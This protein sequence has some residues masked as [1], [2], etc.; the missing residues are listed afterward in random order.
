AR[1]MPRSAGVRSILPLDLL[2]NG[3]DYEQ[4]HGGNLRHMIAQEGAPSLTWRSTPLD[5][6]LGHCRL[7]DLKSGLEQFAVD[8]PRSPKWVLDA[9]SP[10]QSAQLRVD[11]RPPSNQARLPTPVPTKSGPMPTHER[12]G[13]NDL[14][15]LQNRWKP[16]IQ[17]DKEPAIAVREPGPPLNL[18]PQNDQLMSERR[19]LCCVY[20]LLSL[21]RHSSRRAGLKRFCYPINADKVFGTHRAPRDEGG[22]SVG[23]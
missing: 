19:I 10:D 9:H 21:S 20:S 12:L 22:V 11:L 6:V 8:T 2:A 18:T 16:S 3:R 13:L 1:G 7:R 4:I 23:E 15:D 5:Y 17:L 14:D